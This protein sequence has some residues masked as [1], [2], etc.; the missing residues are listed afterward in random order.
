MK[1]MSSKKLLLA[2]V[3]AGA[4]GASGAVSAQTNFEVTATVQNAIE[5]Q[6]D[7]PLNFGTLFVVNASDAVVSY[8]S[9]SAS[10]GNVTTTANPGVPATHL[11]G[12]ARGEFRL[13]GL[14][15]DQEV[16][17]TFH[18]PSGSQPELANETTPGTAACE[19]TATNET[20]VLL[21]PA[22]SDLSV[23]KPSA[24]PPRFC[25]TA[26]TAS[27][28]TGSGNLRAGD[29]VTAFDHSGD[30]P[31]FIGGVISTMAVPALHSNHSYS[32]LVHT[33]QFGMAAT[34]R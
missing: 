33:G 11:G 4:L 22:G 10:T 24:A 18:A 25:M 29:Y 3:V 19:E 17:L 28:T 15:A 12:H 23:A 21:G 32:P 16:D 27:T 14:G 5:V 31:F 34:F 9:L 7:T 8:W 6:Q 13:V 30:L 26:L 1:T 2:S 20:H